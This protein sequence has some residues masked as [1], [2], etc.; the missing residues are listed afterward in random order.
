M[1]ANWANKKTKQTKSLKK[2][3]SDLAFHCA[4]C[5]ALVHIIFF[6]AQKR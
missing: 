1:Q 6:L 4:V 5:A 2:V 3:R